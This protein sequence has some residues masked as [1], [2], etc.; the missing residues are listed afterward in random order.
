MTIKSTAPGLG[1]A[2]AAVGY[3]L[4]DIPIVFAIF[5]GLV[6]GTLAAW[7]K[8]AANRKEQGTSLG[9][10]VAQRAA[11]WLAIGVVMLGIADFADLS[12]RVVGMMATLA[13]FIGYDAL[14]KLAE[15]WLH[16]GEKP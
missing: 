16:T 11:V 1:A 10:W 14:T 2:L 4:N 9:L 8:E 13:S 7:P 5:V 12:V 15:K 3:S 6:A